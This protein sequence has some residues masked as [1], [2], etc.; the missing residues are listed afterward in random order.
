MRD[1]ISRV[2]TA[3]AVTLPALAH[4][5]SVIVT[6]APGT[7]GAPPQDPGV[8]PARPRRTG[9]VRPYSR[10]AG[11]PHGFGSPEWW[12]THR[13][14]GVPAR[15]TTSV[16]TRPAPHLSPRVPDGRHRRGRLGGSFG[17]NP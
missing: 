17:E 1:F 7:V 9:R 2:M 13:V 15:S 5:R 10:S 4:P 12:E 16:P 3:F 6:L 11:P 8:I 14:P